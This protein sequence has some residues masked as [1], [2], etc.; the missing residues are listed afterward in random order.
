M[1]T[2]E[3]RFG[4]KRKASKSKIVE[5]ASSSIE[6]SMELEAEHEAAM[7]EDIE[8]GSDKSE[9][10]DLIS[11]MKENQKKQ[12]V[13]PSRQIIFR[14]TIDKFDK[15]E[16]IKGNVSFQKFYADMTDYFLAKYK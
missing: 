5:G 8:I 16:K 13:L 15:I 10:D 2:L 7:V 3:A 4:N 1:T 12:K 6:S 9:N 14:L 11:F